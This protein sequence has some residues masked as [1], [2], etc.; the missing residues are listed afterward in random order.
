MIIEEFSDLS[1]EN[2]D[3]TQEKQDIELALLNSNFQLITIPYKDYTN[4]EV[5]YSN[6]DPSINTPPP[7]FY[8]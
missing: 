8:S 2:D 1:Q 3:K 4:K 7:N 6:F 5:S